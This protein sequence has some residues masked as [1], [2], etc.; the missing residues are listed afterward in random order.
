MKGHG[1]KLSRKQ[2]QA[3]AA[4][5]LQPT[6]GDAAKSIGVGEVTLW[7]WL[8]REDFQSA[9]M[10]AKKEAVAQAVARLQQITSKAVDTLQAIME[11]VEAPASSRVTA[12]RVVLETSL[13]AIELEDLAA[14]VE[15]LEKAA[16][17]R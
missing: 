7:R 16:A 3:I 15:Q 6:I 2:E 17:G 1:E 13:K 14:R 5:L 4:L 12:A 10:Q 8:K 11:D 9:Y